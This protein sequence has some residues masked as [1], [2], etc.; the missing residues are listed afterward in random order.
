MSHPKI[1]PWLS[2]K[3]F[4]FRIF[5]YF[6]SWICFHYFL[7]Q[8]DRS[9]SPPIPT[10]QNQE[11]SNS[12]PIPTLQA[13][14]P[15]AAASQ[16]EPRSSS[17]PIPTLQ[18]QQRSNSPPIPTLQQNKVGNFLEIRYRLFMWRSQCAYCTT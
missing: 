17:P 18:N 16:A 8:V 10:L 12:P 14:P 6:Q 5:P 9:A 2:R 11:R 3:V 4:R 7:Q 1:D 13:K 15:A